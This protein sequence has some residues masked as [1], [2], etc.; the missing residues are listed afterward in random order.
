V[1]RGL[2]TAIDI[3]NGIHAAD[4]LSLVME[5]DL[6]V[7]LFRRDGWS[8]EQMLEWS[9][10]NATEGTV[11]IIPTSWKGTSVFRICIVSPDTRADAVLGV[12]D[13]MRDPA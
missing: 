6:S 3:A 12:L 10:R 9:D 11:L 13:T 2:R 5:P 4:H 1:E 7:V 8:A